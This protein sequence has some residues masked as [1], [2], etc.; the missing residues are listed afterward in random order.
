MRLFE[1]FQEYLNKQQPINESINDKNI[2]KAVFLAGGPGAGKSFIVGKAFAGTSY[3]IVNSDEL[4]EYLLKTRQGIK[5]LILAGERTSTDV[6]TKGDVTASALDIDPERKEI[7]DLQMVY[8]EDA[9]K[10]ADGKFFYLINGLLPLIIDGTGAN[11]DK[12][13]K[14]ELILKSF[15]YDTSMIFVDTTLDVALERNRSR[16]RSVDDSVVIEKWNEVQENRDDFEK[17]FGS[18]FFRVDNSS[19]TKDEEWQKGIINIFNRSTTTPLKNPVGQSIIANL[20]A[21][22]GKYL[23]D[24]EWTRDELKKIKKF[25]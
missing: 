9:K 22:K 18:N 1:T 20:K 23:E 12:V 16:P 13:L 11:Y 3:K 21:N 14:Q 5:D 17:H 4:F 2:L 10:K 8:R 25:L 15:G 6:L 7:H 24:L 19:A